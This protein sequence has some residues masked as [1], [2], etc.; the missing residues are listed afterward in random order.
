MDA[1][2]CS[3]YISKKP[4]SIT[5]LLIRYLGFGILAAIISLGFAA[6]AN[7][8]YLMSDFAR[9]GTYIDKGKYYFLDYGQYYFLDKGQYHLIGKLDYYLGHPFYP[10]LYEKSIDQKI[11]FTKTINEA[12]FV[13]LAEKF[14]I[15]DYNQRNSCCFNAGEAIY[16]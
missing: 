15:S 12:W 10:R 3:D 8:I 5:Q 13:Y 4:Q 14:P 9:A 6:K 16:R 11:G 7:A 2:Y 1:E